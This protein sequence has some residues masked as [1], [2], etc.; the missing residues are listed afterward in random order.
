MPSGTFS[1]D[2][3]AGV[4]SKGFRPLSSV[5]PAVTLPRVPWSLTPQVKILLSWVRATACIPPAAS[6]TT[7]TSSAERRRLRRGRFTSV[8]AGGPSVPSPNS[9]DDPSPKT[10]TSSFSIGAL[11]MV[12]LGLGLGSAFGAARDFFAGGF[13]SSSSSSSSLPFLLLRLVALVDVVVLALVALVTFPFAPEVALADFA[14][15]FALPFGAAL[16]APLAAGFAAPL[17]ARA[18]SSLVISSCE[19]EKERMNAYSSGQEP[20]ASCPFHLLS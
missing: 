4:A 19:G 9:P 7:P 2:T 1:I 11:L 14:A 16:V 20:L 5:S 18:V 10:K 8:M 6:W 17:G 3:A 13:S 12:T 15:G